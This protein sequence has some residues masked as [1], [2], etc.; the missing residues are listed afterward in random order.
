MAVLSLSE[1]SKKFSEK[2]V[3]HN[4]SCKFDQAGIYA[5]TGESGIG[6]STL[7]K[8][9]SGI[10]RN[11]RGSVF[12]NDQMISQKDEYKW[13]N[14]R[15]TT[16]G[17]QFQNFALCENLSA[18]ENTILPFIVNG[19]FSNDC[20]EKAITY[21]KRLN[22][23]DPLDEAIGSMSGGE[24]QRVAIAR[25]LVKCPQVIILDEPTANLDESN[26]R[27]VVC[28]LKEMV[29]KEHCIIIAA[30]HSGYLAN[31]ADRILRLHHTKQGAE[32]I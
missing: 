21:L 15:K 19:T 16:L 23:S 6:K 13:A 27:Q 29:I 20:R 24:R 5:L 8:I 7:L 18:I 28:V 2:K 32:L 4:I 12:Y 26:E 14:I 9:I 10:D 3:L 17:I 1:I 31:H 11:F 25:A 30:T 22:L